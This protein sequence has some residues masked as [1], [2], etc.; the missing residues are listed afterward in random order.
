LLRI[1]SWAVWNL[2]QERFARD[3]GPPGTEVYIQKR[4]ISVSIL[5]HH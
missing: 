1:V 3:T 2:K 5:H 4:T